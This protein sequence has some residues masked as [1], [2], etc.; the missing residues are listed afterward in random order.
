MAVITNIATLTY[1]GGTVNSN[2]TQGELLTTLSVTKTATSATYV[3]GERIVYAINLVNTGTAALTNLTV[4]DDLGAFDFNGTTLTPLTYVPGS[5]RYFVNGTPETAGAVTAGPPLTV[6]GVTV[7]AGGNITLL[8]TAIPNAYAPLAEG[9]TIT[10]GVT[11][12][13]GGISCPASASETVSVRVAPLLSIAKAMSPSVVTE[14]GELTY[15]LTVSNNGNADAVATDSIV[16]S[17]TF[18]PRLGNITVTL[19]GVTLTEGTDYTYDEATGAFATTLG[20]VTVPAAAFTQDPM[21]GEQIITPG[22]ATLTIS[23]T[24]LGCANPTPTK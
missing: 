22:T 17:D 7:P 21:S 14:N 2:V 8:Y 15:T 6:S 18:D 11:V 12:T 13:G 10:N 20:T 3:P 23:G 19:D 24:V 9:S 16:I 5:V 1:S 4:S